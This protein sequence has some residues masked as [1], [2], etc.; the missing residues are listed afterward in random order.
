M[1]GRPR[2]RL[3]RL[4]GPLVVAGAVFVSCGGPGPVSITGA[5]TPAVGD[6]A[7]CAALIAAL[8]DS[9]GAGMDRREVKPPVANAAAYGAKPDAVLTCG[10]TGVAASYQPTTVLSAI[11][12]VGWF[13]EALGD[14]TR[15]S[16]PTRTPQVVLTLPADQQAFEVLVALAPSVREHTRPT[17]GTEG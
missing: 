16:T 3:F 17:A 1:T 11:D 4:A 6:R 14:R 5:P 7:A 9:L 13:T 15:Y 2:L 12:E 10:A 8:P